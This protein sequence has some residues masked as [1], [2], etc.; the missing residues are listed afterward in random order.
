MKRFVNGDEVELQDDGAEITRLGDRLYV[1]TPEGTFTAVAVR[2]GDVT[3]VSY[4]GRQFQ[5]EERQNRARV[6]SHVGSGELRAPMPGLIVDVRRQVGDAIKKGETILVLEAMKTQQPFNA[7]FDGTVTQISV[8][9]GDQVTDG[10]VLAVV[11]A[12]GDV[13]E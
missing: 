6:S 10:S 8:S 4:K 9:K 7:P 12:A 3:H 13:G 5:V 2:V 11:T 1:R